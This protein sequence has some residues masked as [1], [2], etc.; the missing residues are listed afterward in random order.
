MGL[1][2]EIRD[3]EKIYSGSRI[4]GSKRHRILDPGSG[5]STLLGR[6]KTAI[7]CDSFENV[8]LNCKH[9]PVQRQHTYT[10]SNRANFRK[11][12]SFLGSQSCGFG[13][14]TLKNENTFSAGAGRETG[15][16]RHMEHRE[17]GA[18]P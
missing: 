11:L 10:S 4:Q 18:G 2:S 5:S 14:A 7:K 17:T 1:G 9:S 6:E 8:R 3:P 13:P 12:K 15:H 16:P